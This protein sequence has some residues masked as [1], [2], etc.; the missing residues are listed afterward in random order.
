MVLEDEKPGE[1]TSS[2]FA[3]SES[4]HNSFQSSRGHNSIQSLPTIL[5]EKTKG[6][7]IQ[8][9]IFIQQKEWASPTTEKP[10]LNLNSSPFSFSPSPPEKNGVKDRRSAASS[11][12]LDNMLNHD[13]NE[14]G[15][16][17]SKNAF[18]K[19]G[20]LDMAMEKM[21]A[22]MTSFSVEDDM[23]TMETTST[24]RSAIQM[25]NSMSVIN[26]TPSLDTDAQ[27]RASGGSK[28][29]KWSFKDAEKKKKVPAPLNENES[30]ESKSKP[31]ER[32]PIDE[33]TPKENLPELET[34]ITSFA[35]IASPEST[36]D[37]TRLYSK[38]MSCINKP[39]EFLPL[40]PKYRAKKTSAIQHKFV[41][42]NRPDD[43]LGPKTAGSKPPK[44]S[45][46][47]KKVLELSD[48]GDE[49]N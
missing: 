46:T 28:G 49:D 29:K 26:T 3:D 24:T 40:R 22:S 32:K 13:A 4:G 36:D 48:M 39:D 21:E 18:P 38:S 20:L 7:N 15:L 23:Q 45:W 25:W 41:A 10:K 2:D 17:R 34:S 6:N 14:V 30:D 44:R 19:P 43:W 8:V 27:S 47:A 16:E 31:Q 37:V 5:G 11:I 12:Q 33:K 35:S 9:P 1:D 42:H